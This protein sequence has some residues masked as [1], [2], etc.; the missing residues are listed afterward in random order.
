M[1]VSGMRFAIAA[2]LVAMVGGCAGT[3]TTPTGGSGGTAGTTTLTAPGQSATFLTTPAFT[4]NLTLAAGGQYLIAVVNTDPSYTTTEGFTLAGNYSSG[5]AEH[6]APVVASGVPMTAGVRYSAAPSPTPR[7]QITSPAAKRMASLRKLQR[8][9]LQ[10]LDRNV[11]IFQSYAGLRSTV[12]G[13]RAS[14]NMVRPLGCCSQTVG[15]VQKVYIAKAFGATCADVDSIGA[16]TV[17]VGQHIIVLADTSLTNWPA[18]LRPDS[19]F[20]QTFASEYDGVT[21]PHIQT[22]IGNPLAL[23]NTLSGVGKV[24]TVISPV[25]NAFGGGIVAFVDGCDF[26]PVTP[27]QS[28]DNDTEVFYYWTPD[29]AQGWTVEP[30]EELMRAT[31]AHETKHLV[32]YTDHIMNNGFTVPELIWLEE[33]LAQESSEIWERHF[34]QAK[35]KGNANFD[36]TVGCE[37]NLGPGGPQCDSAGTKPI[38]L[39][40]SHLPFLFEYLAEESTS[41]VG[42]GLGTD[43]PSNYG[44]GWQFARWATDQY[45]STEPSFI[46]SLVNEPALNGLPNLAKHTG[47]SIEEL[48]VYWSLASAIFDTA[49]YTAADVRITNPS[50]NF[51][52]IFYVGQT[53]L[54]CMGGVPCGLFS[55]NGSPTPALPVQPVVY[56]TN[57]AINATV[58]SVPGTTAYYALL[59]ATNG[60]TETLQLKSSSGGAISPSSGFRVGIV[61][62]K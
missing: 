38:A 49:T 24:T 6:V 21:W 39:V 20:Y 28:L 37:L 5:S 23:D 57:V 29:P 46:T 52:N 14:A 44:S 10:M 18:A 26:N 53:G 33:G 36:Q 48:L 47:K 16:R 32:S 15:T 25:L 51:G 7:Y 27:G 55:A 22:Y 11:Q 60:G 59:A 62:V 35:W 9:H 2:V 31:A 54:T 61:R 8:T 45:A 4:T 3:P 41:P 50:F 42:H 43:T 17:A 13:P 40:G 12:K 58:P 56:G 34:N 30:W 19:G 1:A